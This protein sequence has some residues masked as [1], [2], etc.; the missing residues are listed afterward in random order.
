MKDNENSGLTA[1][2]AAA[3]FGGIVTSR[4]THPGGV[5]REVV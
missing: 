1:Q 4:R 5:N 3:T 2:T